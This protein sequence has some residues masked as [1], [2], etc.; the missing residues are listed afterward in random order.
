MRINSQGPN[1][2]QSP[3]SQANADPAQQA[4][5]EL[6]HLVMKLGKALEQQQAQQQGQQGTSSTGAAADPNAAS[7]S[8]SAQQP[9]IASLL[10]KILS[11][12]AQL[13]NSNGA[14]QGAGTA[15]SGATD[16]NAATG[17]TAASGANGTSSLTADQQNQVQQLI[18]ALQ[19]AGVL[20]QSGAT[21]PNAASG[22]AAQ[23]QS[24]TG[25][26]QND[27]YQA[28]QGTHHK[29]HHH[30]KAAPPADPS[31]TSTGSDSSSS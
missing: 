29:H 11:G 24:G 9:D 20:P 31:T 17:S 16:P 13:Q 25:Y 1:A 26:P 14:A 5:H 28:A 3:Q 15:A 6:K 12:L 7:Q 2:L 30:H 22:A 23:P 19:Q 8:S 4:F 10:Q 18:T 21:D 27:S